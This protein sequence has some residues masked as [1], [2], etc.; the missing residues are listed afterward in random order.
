[1]TIT[2]KKFS[3]KPFYVEGLQVTEEN[4]NEVA[5]WCGGEIQESTPKGD[6]KKVPF[7]KV[8][9][10]RPLHRRQTMAYAGDWILKAGSGFKVYTEAAF[11]SNFDAVEE[12]PEELRVVDEKSEDI[13]DE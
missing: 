5:E 6:D 11:D 12:A 1:M 7:I 4:I 10:R 2:T 9:V 8:N 3:R 13:S